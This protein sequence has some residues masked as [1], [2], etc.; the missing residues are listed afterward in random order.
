MMDA[1]IVYAWVAICGCVIILVLIHDHQKK[2]ATLKRFHRRIRSTRRTVSPRKDE[3]LQDL[4]ADVQHYA[5]VVFNFKPDVPVIVKYSTS[6]D[7]YKMSMPH[8]GKSLVPAGL[9]ISGREGIRIFVEQKPENELFYILAHEYAHAWQ[10]IDKFSSSS[11]EQ[12]EG[13]AE[14]FAYQLTEFAGYEIPK[15]IKQP[16]SYN[17]YVSGRE[18]FNT[19][20]TK[21]GW[22]G[23]L[24]AGTSSKTNIK[25]L[26]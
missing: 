10:Q 26:K 8:N 13:F 12:N 7:L 19:L 9:C 2:K 25:M 3:F 22:I 16:L 6:I 23:A 1:P 20:E 18:K 11:I 5:W 15:H 21:Y 24:K 14:W 4:F 17:L